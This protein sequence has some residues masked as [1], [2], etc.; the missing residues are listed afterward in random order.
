MN[1]T[2]TRHYIFYKTK[3]QLTRTAAN[4]GFDV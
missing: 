3:G 2:D 4:A 1:N